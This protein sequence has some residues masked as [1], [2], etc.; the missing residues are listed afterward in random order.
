[1]GEENVVNIQFVVEVLGLWQFQ[2]F[3]WMVGMDVIATSTSSKV[4]VTHQI[5]AKKSKD[6][7]KI[8]S[9]IL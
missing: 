2:W 8:W 6:N 9:S 5:K 3:A 1:M 7:Y 4:N